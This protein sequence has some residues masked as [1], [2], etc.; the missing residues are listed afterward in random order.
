MTDRAF[1]HGRV[2][3]A[4]RVAET[5]V[6]VSDGVIAAIG[7][8][9]G[10][11]WDIVDLEG[12]Y[13]LPGLVELHTDNLE[14]HFE[15]RP[16]VFWPSPLAA[17]LAHD[18]QVAAAGITTVLD[19][20]CIGDLDSDGVR[21][22]MLE[23]S[24]AA[25]REACGAAV[26]RADHYLH[27]R[28]ELA[29]PGLGESFERL[30]D[31]PRLR[32]ISVMDHT[33]GQRQWTD[34]AT[35]AQYH[36][37]EGWSAAELEAQVVLR[38]RLMA[39]HSARHRA[40]IVA[41]G[42]ALGVPLASHDDTTRD[43]VAE[44]VAEGIAIAEFP[45]TRLAAELARANGMAVIMGAPNL[46]RGGSHSGNVATAELAEA[47]LVNALSSDYVPSSLL[48]AAFLLHSRHGVPLAASVAMVSGQP[49]AMVGLDDRGRIAEGLRADL[50][51][52][53]LLGEVPVVRGAWCQGRR[54][55]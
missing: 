45:T 4:D 12:D 46:V 31:E 30:V 51:R 13:L 18:G 54:V 2:V 10:Q 22:A 20:V 42:R 28:C 53:R 40:Q 11:A 37:D 34:I 6:T 48:H 36:R 44:A 24:I 29:D 23:R 55:L 32:L 50:I 5:E 27:L 41:R 19:A 15:P 26:L 7:R 47:G 49:A 16:G 38:Q 17:L 8:S 52:V 9:P 25:L 14:K 35:F 33:P 3:L 39:D 43:H 1:V 21:A